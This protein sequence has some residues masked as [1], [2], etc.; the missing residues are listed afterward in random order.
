[1]EV[2]VWTVAKE[3]WRVE[4]IERVASVVERRE[5]QVVKCERRME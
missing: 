1:M 4:R 5:L 2:W 3:V